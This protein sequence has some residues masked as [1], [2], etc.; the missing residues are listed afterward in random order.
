MASIATPKNQA[1]VLNDW[2]S[3]KAEFW[4]LSGSRAL[5]LLSL[6]GVLP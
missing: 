5:Y 1:H 4:Q 6:Q 3:E 2:R